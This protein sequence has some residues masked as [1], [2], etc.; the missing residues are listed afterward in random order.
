MNVFTS[1]LFKVKIS[2]KWNENS[3]RR[4]RALYLALCTPNV[5]FLPLYEAVKEIERRKTH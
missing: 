5:L 3:L 2:V 4:Q 1:F